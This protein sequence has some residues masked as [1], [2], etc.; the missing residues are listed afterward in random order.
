MP[1]FYFQVVHCKTTLSA[2]LLSVLERNL[3]MVDYICGSTLS[4]AVE[5]E[6][7]SNI[8]LKVGRRERTHIAHCKLIS[9]LCLYVCLFL[10]GAWIHG[11]A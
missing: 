4:D 6:D 11:L 10:A 8:L 5:A 7:K 1:Y 9:I 3:E 2:R